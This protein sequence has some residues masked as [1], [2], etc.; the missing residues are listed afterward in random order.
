MD[1]I[2]NTINKRNFALPTVCAHNN[3]IRIDQSIDKDTELQIKKD[4]HVH[5]VIKY[6]GKKGNGPQWDVQKRCVWNNV[7]LTQHTFEE[8]LKTLSRL[9]LFLPIS[10]VSLEPRGNVFVAWYE[11]PVMK[12]EWLLMRVI[13]S[14]SHQGR[15]TS[16]CGLWGCSAS[17]WWSGCWSCYCFQ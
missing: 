14:T 3:F 12:S 1:P 15:T 6:R 17:S 16:L 11:N 5:S 2:C 4:F 13:C 9:S 10:L 7:F 8:E